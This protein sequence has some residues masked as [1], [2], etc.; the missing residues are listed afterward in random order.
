MEKNYSHEETAEI[1]K[2]RLESDIELIK[3]GAG[4]KIDKKAQINLTLDPKQI[5]KIL[6]TEDKETI[7]ETVKKY[8]N[9][10]KNLPLKFRADKDVVTTAVKTHG[11]NLEYASKELRADSGVAFEAIKNYH[12]AIKYV[13]SELL[14][15]RKF[16]LKIVGLGTEGGSIL[17]SLSK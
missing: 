5:Q 14:S 9:F 3:N 10:F 6:E 13:S 11:V 8:N 12:A 16:I 1:E 4:Y 15:D 17:N 2:S 7:I